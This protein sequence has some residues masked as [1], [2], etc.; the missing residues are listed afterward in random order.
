MRCA[1]PVFWPLLTSTRRVIAAHHGSPARLALSTEKTSHSPGTFLKLCWRWGRRSM[2]EPRRTPSAASA[3]SPPPWLAWLGLAVAAPAAFAALTVPPPVSGAPGI[4]GLHE[5]PGW[6]KHPPLPGQAAAAVAMHHEAPTGA[7]PA[8]LSA[9]L[10]Q[11]AHQAPSPVPGHT[12]VVGGMPGW[13]IA[14]IAAGAASW[15][16][17]WPCSSTGPGPAGG[18]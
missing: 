9:Y 1:G 18:T 14:L 6:N 10:H 16:P 17:P 3:I 2:A 7:L 5:P 8:P 4:A 11:L 13:Q 12:V 15:P